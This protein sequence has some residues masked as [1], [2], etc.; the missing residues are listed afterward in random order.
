MK[1]IIERDKLIKPLQVASA[2]LSNRPSLPILGNI[3]LQVSNNILHL[4]ATDLEIEIETR[5][6]LSEGNE[7]LSI[8]VPAKK[9][10]DI[11]RSLPS[12]SMITLEFIDNRLIIHSGRSRFTLSTLPADEFP[13]LENW[14][15]E[16]SFSLNQSL[17]KRLIDS[18]QFSMANQDVRY[19]LNGMLFEI[20]DNILKTVATDG[21]RLAVSS[22]SLIS[23]NIQNKSFI[24]PRKGVLELAK[25]L[26][27]QDEIITLELGG[28]NFKAHLPELVFTSKLIDGR[29]PEYKKVFPR[30]PDKKIICS[31]D[32]LKQSLSRVAILSNEKFKGVRLFVE[33]NQLKITANNPE[34]EEAEEIMDVNYTFEA[35][36]IGFNVTYLLDILNSLRCENIQIL[37]SNAASSV[38]IENLNDAATSYVVMPMR[39]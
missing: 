10:L 39:L 7:D 5:I 6:A 8:T 3:L 24:L 13:N 22:Q 20:E 26:T 25:L 37:L 35:L 18:V 33:N 23:N 28:N 34:K 30:N 32:E 17:L 4:T 21:H 9:F 1:Y 31:C 15:T 36:E 12:E 2:P 27:D 11:C 16:I 38:Q 29:Y 19:Y 14:Q